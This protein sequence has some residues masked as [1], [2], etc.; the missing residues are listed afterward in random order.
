MV[1]GLVVLIIH[2]TYITDTAQGQKATNAEEVLAKMLATYE[3]AQSYED[4]GEMRLLQNAKTILSEPRGSK[5]FKIMVSFQIHFEKPQLFRFDW[6]NGLTKTSRESVIWS[7]GQEHYIWAPDRVTADDRFNLERKKGFDYLIDRVVKPSNGT[8]LPIPG[9]LIPTLRR[10]S[11]ADVARHLSEVKIIKEAFVDGEM[12]YVV[13][14]KASN[15][16]WVFWI[17]KSSFL[18]R[19]MKRGRYSEMISMRGI[20]AGVLSGVILLSSIKAQ[21]NLNSAKVILSEMLNTY[22]STSTYQDVGILRL[23]PQDSLASRSVES[24]FPRNR[25]ARNDLS[26]S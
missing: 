14:A 21:T 16:P 17:G 13:S 24:L 22:R 1:L 12:C 11:F 4:V 9:L 6:R 23:T 7:D 3:N 8:I 15:D 19:K 18:L 20:L 5:Q 25:R 2:C 10:Y 26:A